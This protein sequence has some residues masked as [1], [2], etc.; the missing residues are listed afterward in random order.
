[1][2]DSEKTERRKVKKR[3]K[4]LEKKIKRVDR[5]IKRGK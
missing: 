2:T 4:A 3:Y 1:M 5:E